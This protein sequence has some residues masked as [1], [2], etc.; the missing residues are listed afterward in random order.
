MI[1]LSNTNE[2]IRVSLSYAITTSQMSCIVSYRDTS[3]SSITPARNVIYTNGTSAIDLVDSPASSTQRV[4]DYISVYNND[5]STNVVTVSFLTDITSYRL[6]VF[7]LAPTEKLEY[8]DG[9]GFRVVSNSQSIKTSTVF[10]G[11][12][13]TANLSMMVL[14]QD[15]I[16]ISNG[17]SFRTFPDLRL[18]MTANIKYWFRYVIFY[19]T[20]STL[21][22]TRFNLYG[23]GGASTYLHHLY[24]NSI[25][26]SSETY[27]GGVSSYNALPVSN[28]G[29]A[30]TSGNVAILEGIIQPDY[31]T[32]L[33]I[34]VS[35]E[36]TG[37]LTIK[38]NSFLQ[39][40]QLL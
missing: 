39:Y 1:I 36:S 4:I 38:A 6:A 31:V 13:D 14:N 25:T 37:T 24:R 23:D 9:Q 2:K 40:E 28:L 16:H 34:N 29:S 19:N 7:Q 17:D 35:C 12:A 32:T 15:F 30:S 21:I 3:S 22:G 8:H 33:G 26:T 20:N 10:D 5:S 27:I 18:A 11:I